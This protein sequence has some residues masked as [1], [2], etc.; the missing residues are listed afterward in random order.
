M[1]TRKPTIGF[2]VATIVV[3]SLA[4]PLSFGPACWIN[5][6]TGFGGRAVSIVYRPIIWIAQTRQPQ[7]GIRLV[8]ELVLSPRPNFTTRMPGRAI[9]WYAML[10]TN[11]DRIP[12]IRKDAIEWYLRINP[13]PELGP[14]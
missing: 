5:E 1:G 10:G 13:E 6:R 12:V 9:R 14:E 4:Y 3:V 7:P 11:R 2:W 8:P